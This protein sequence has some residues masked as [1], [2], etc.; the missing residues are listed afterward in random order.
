MTEDE[1]E[2]LLQGHFMGNIHPD[3]I[4]VLED[5]R[6]QKEQEKVDAAVQRSNKERPE[7]ST[8]KKSTSKT[9]KKSQANIDKKLFDNNETSQKIA[10][11]VGNP[12]D[13]EIA[14]AVRLLDKAGYKFMSPENQQQ[15]AV[16]NNNF[17]SLMNNPNFYK[18]MATQYGLQ[19]Q[20]AQMAMMFGVN[21]NNQN[22]SFDS[23]L[24]F[25][26]MQ[27]QQK[28]QDPTQRR[29]NTELIKS[30]MMSQM[31]GSYDIGFDSNKNNR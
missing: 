25:L 21:N 4:R 13:K 10:G 24:P 11:I 12:S 29:Q 9:K 23:M 3:A 7:A 15:T 28:N 1:F 30:M 27:D 14:D 2:R 22:N 31:M 19:D 16:Q 17:N 5:T 6:L 18:Q 8:T 20:S 26:L